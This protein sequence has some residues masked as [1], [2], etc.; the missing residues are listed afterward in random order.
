[1]LIDEAKLAAHL[2]H[3]NI[4]QVYDLGSVE[5]QYY[6]ALEL[7]N[8]QNLR[9]IKDKLYSLGQKLPIEHSILI[10][11]ALCQALYYAH[12]KCD[13]NNTPLNIIHRDI[14]P[15]NVLISYD[16]EVKLTDFGIAKAATIVSTT[17][18]GVLKGKYGY[19]SPEQVEGLDIDP[20][21]DIFSLGII[22]FE[23]L[24]GSKLFDSDS[25]LKLLDM[26]REAKVPTPS[27]IVADLPKEIDSIVLKSLA[28]DPN[29]RYQDAYEFLETLHDFCLAS[30]IKTS[31]RDLSL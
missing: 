6:I 8:G 5:G 15:A 20:R 2:T 27:T 21:S 24:T 18:T 30:G 12:T 29:D 19:L 17:Q 26:I 22:L 3:A 1:M 11:Q 23:L 31:P 13:L 10:I 28:K 16:G 7:V 4:V 9:S 14:S 25:Q